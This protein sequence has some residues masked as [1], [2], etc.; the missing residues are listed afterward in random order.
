MTFGER[1]KE[2][3]DQS[4]AVSKE[5][6]GKAGE[7]AQDWGERGLNASRELVNKAGAKAQDLGERGVLMLE[8]K[9]LEGQAQRLISRLGT[10]VYNALAERGESS[11]TA[12]DPVIQPLLSELAA[13]KE[14]IEKRETEVQSRRR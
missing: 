11:V 1:M 6:A 10:E 5:L 2:L 3:M 4:V 13:L 9:Q 7:K 14:A 8:I 12:G